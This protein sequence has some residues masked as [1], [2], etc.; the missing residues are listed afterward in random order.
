LPEFQPDTRVSLAV[1]QDFQG[2]VALNQTENVWNYTFIN[3][4]P[5]ES[6]AFGDGLFLPVAAPIENIISPT[7]WTFIS[8]NTT[9]VQWLY[10]EDTPYPNAIAPGGSLSGFQFESTAPGVEDTYIL[11]PFDSTS[12]LLQN[13][14]T[15]RILVPSLV[16]APSALTA[17]VIGA[18]PDVVLLRRRHNRK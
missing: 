17:F 2:R 7:G 10:A 1:A 9:F 3:D 6:V 4:E 16:P 18:V 12:G 5:I 15:G 13:E 14:V 8:D 11:K